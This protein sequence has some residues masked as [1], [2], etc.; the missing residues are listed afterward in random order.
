MRFAA[1][2][3]GLDA[4]A[5]DDPPHVARGPRTRT[6]WSFR[7][8]AGGERA[9]RSPSGSAGAKSGPVRAGRTRR[10]RA[11]GGR[12]SARRRTWR[13]RRRGGPRTRT[14]GGR[15]RFRRSHCEARANGATGGRMIPMR[16]PKPAVRSTPTG[17]GAAGGSRRGEEEPDAR[18]EEA[19][20]VVERTT[21]ERPRDRVQRLVRPGAELSE[22]ESRGTAGPGR[23]RVAAATAGAARRPASRAAHGRVHGSRLRDGVEGARRSPQLAREALP[24]DH[25]RNTRTESGM[26]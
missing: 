13:S 20:S 6:R 7:R 2:D 26:S 11:G 3:L 12:R 19:S 14:R 16:T 21:S 18:E 8:E 9:R 22:D 24:T 4:L 23:G 5:L 10:R 15:R 17:R 1:V 25:A